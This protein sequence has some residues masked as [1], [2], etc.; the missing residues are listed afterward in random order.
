MEAANHL[1]LPGIL[2]SHVHFREPG[3]THKE[4]FASGTAAAASMSSDAGA[5]ATLGSR[6]VWTP[7]KDFIIGAE[8]LAS[9]HHSGN[10]GQTYTGTTAV[11][12][13]RHVRAPIRRPTLGA[14]GAAA[15]GDRAVRA[16]LVGAGA[17][18]LGRNRA[19]RN[20]R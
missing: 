17:H 5:I 3:L 13:V 7:V 10:N 19:A 9:F 4:D 14:R 6:T 8:V 18:R 15:R 20:G 12:T 16:G 2:D 11:A 1:V